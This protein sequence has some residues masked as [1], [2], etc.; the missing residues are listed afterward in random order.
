MLT[1]YVVCCFIFDL[2][3]HILFINKL[4]IFHFMHFRQT[5][6]N[7]FITNDLETTPYTSYITFL[8][9]LYNDNVFLNLFTHHVVHEVTVSLCSNSVNIYSHA[10]KKCKLL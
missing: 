8:K 7:S 10:K 4:K 1:Y 2:F 6:Y 5:A 9:D 3:V